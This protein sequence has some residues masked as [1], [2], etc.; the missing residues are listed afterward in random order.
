MDVLRYE[1]GHV[2]GRGNEFHEDAVLALGAGHEDGF[3][4]VAG[5]VHRFDDLVR[6]QGNEFHCRVVVQRQ[7]ILRFVA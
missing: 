2:A 1:H 5:F 7:P 6:L 4:L 3:D